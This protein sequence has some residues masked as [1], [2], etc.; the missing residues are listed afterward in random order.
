MHILFQID[1]IEKLKLASDSSIELA[2]EASSRGFKIFISYPENLFVKAHDVYTL[3]T[4]ISFDNSELKL[5][6]SSYRTLNDFDIIFIRQDPP[7]DINYVINC[8]ILSLVKGPL[9]INNPLSIV[10]HSEKIFTHE[11][12]EFMPKTLISNNTEQILE[13]LDKQ[14]Q[15]VI[16]PIN[17]CGGRGVKLLSATD[18]NRE[19]EITSL[20][21]ETQMPIIIQEFLPNVTKGDT[22]VLLCGNKIIGQVLRVPSKNSITANF[23]AGGNEAY[24][25]LSDKQKEISTKIANYAS[26]NGLYFVGLDFI[27]DY[28]TE[29]NVTSPTGIINASRQMQENLSQKIWDQ[30]TIIKNEIKN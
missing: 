27:G 24:T 9:F 29:I 26:K 19:A 14:K 21:S 3:V 5:G 4:E 10:T 6:N 17:L 23:C 20:Q 1:P 22:R 25:E 7:F 30:I 11:F 28:L 8:Q 13:F 12:A 15:A 16:K 18:K 2:K